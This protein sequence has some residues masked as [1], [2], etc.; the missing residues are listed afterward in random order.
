[1]LVNRRELKNSNQLWSPR[2][3][4]RMCSM[5]FENDQPTSDNP[6]P[7]LNLGYDA[8]RKVKS[9]VPSRRK[10]SYR[11][12]QREMSGTSDDDPNLIIT[13]L[14][15]DDDEIYELPD[16]PLV[17]EKR[18][19][20]VIFMPKHTIFRT[21]Y[22]ENVILSLMIALASLL[23]FSVMCMSKLTKQFDIN[24]EL[25]DKLRKK[26]KRITT[27]NIIIKQ[28]QILL[29]NLTNKNKILGAKV[30]KCKC[31]MPLHLKLLT[32]D[33]L[34]LFHTGIKTVALFTKLH[35]FIVP[36]VRRRWRG[37]KGT[38]ST[39]RRNFF[40]VPKRMGPARKLPSKDEFLLLLMRLRLGLLEKDLATRFNISEGLVSAIFRSW[41][42]CSAE[43]L[44]AYVFV[45]DQGAL[46]ITRPSHFR[47]ASN[48]HSII[49]ATEIFIETPKNLINQRLTWS[50][51]KHH[52]TLK[53]LLACSANSTIVFV[54]KAYCGS[55][56]D[57]ALT[58]DCGYLEKVEPYSQLMADKGFNIMSEC[59]A[60]RINLVI[61]PGKRGQSQMLPK[62]V[63]KTSEI[64]RM[65]ILV[66]QVIRQLK[67]FHILG[68]EIPVNIIPQVDDII[69][70]CAALVNT[71]APIY[72]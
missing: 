62:A 24:K 66:E 51:Y 45:P 52:N 57:K 40:S 31:E 42:R 50:N 12:T 39:L 72:K 8:S 23:A 53:M 27:L 10:L 9:I 41:L 70:V 34:C 69:T 59:E 67:S 35:D 38:T 15:G 29:K 44:S 58:V 46:N 3:Q 6:Y 71:W 4:S 17:E 5:H 2:K 54:S 49:D 30:E 32:T 60:R 18:N 37:T 65:R 16:I 14:E 1:M 19:V 21:A 43:V 11:G 64:A 13:E 28:Q 36:F 68:R 55:I 25:L 7:T 33:K 63:R 22:L 48:L 20:D 61:P 26:E 56:S 47:P